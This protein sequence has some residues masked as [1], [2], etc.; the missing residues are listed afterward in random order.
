MT[1]SIT[2]HEFKGSKPPFE[3][4]IEFKNTGSIGRALDNDFVI[5][6]PDKFVSR[7]HAKCYLDGENWFIKDNSSTATIVNDNVALKK[8]QAFLLSVGDIITLGESTLKVKNIQ[9]P[10]KPKT[11]LPAEDESLAEHAKIEH[12]FEVAP[13]PSI[14]KNDAADA[15]ESRSE[16]ENDE[17]KSS[18]IHTPPKDNTPEVTENDSQFATVPSDNSL[19]FNID[20]FFADEHDVE[21]PA[22]DS[23]LSSTESS[24]E[25]LPQEQQQTQDAPD[26]LP[27]AGSTNEVSQDTMALRAFLRELGIQPEQLIG[28]Q[29]IDI[30]K[31]AGVVLKTLT[32]G[33]M[34]VL[35]A[36]AL[37][38]ERLELDRTQIK[39]I[40]NNPFKFSATP[41]EALAK[42]LTKEPGYLDPILASREAVDDAKAHQMAMISGLNVAI[43]ETIETFDPKS[44][45][46]DYDVGFSLNKKSKYW[47]VYCSI[48]EEIADNA[49]S[50]SNNIFIRHF[51]EHYELQLEKLKLERK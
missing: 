15:P 37:M 3:Q 16:F 35:N 4:E 21:H 28:Q 14:E 8:G 39:Q 5:H 6:D 24:A 17:L 27:Y 1:I 25:A 42:L 41:E 29:K 44:L 30:M 13:E 49:Q 48:Y 51:K 50:D 32:E 19:V 40:K 20:D 34:G 45:E 38:K 9:A 46:H 23:A 2:W 12:V 18:P 10:S 7:F 47:D 36:R 22:Q 26:P 33:M 43:Q 31:E 11:R